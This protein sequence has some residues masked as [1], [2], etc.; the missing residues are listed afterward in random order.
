MDKS[1]KHLIFKEDELQDILD[2][3]FVKVNF[4]L[5]SEE[6]LAVSY[7]AQLYY[8]TIIA[9]HLKRAIKLIQGFK[10]HIK[11]IDISEVKVDED[12]KSSYTVAFELD[13]TKIVVCVVEDSSVYPQVYDTSDISKLTLLLSIIFDEYSG[14]RKVILKDQEEVVNE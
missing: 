9:E 2:S 3:D 10:F 14:T 7:R 12:G 11:E 8:K 13:D 1:S 6:S 5:T 4:I